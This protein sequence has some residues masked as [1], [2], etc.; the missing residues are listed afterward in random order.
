M[1]NKGIGELTAKRLLRF[2]IGI[3]LVF[4][5][6]IGRLFYIQIIDSEN[7]QAKALSQWSRE[8]TISAKRGDITDRNGTVLAQSASAA[9]IVA[10]PKDVAMKKVTDTALACEQIAGLLSDELT[11]DKDTVLGKLKDTTKSQ[12]ILARQITLE[13]ADKVRKIISDNK[14]SGIAINEDTVRAYPNGAFLTQ[15]LGFTDISG[16]GQEGLEKSLDKYLA[17]TDGRVISQVDAQNRK[18]DDGSDEYIAPKDGYSVALT[19]DYVLQSIAEKVCEEALEQNIA[20]AVRCILMNPSTGEI[21]AMV[22]KPDFD[23]NSPP[24]ND[25][26]LLSSLMRNACVT[27]AYEPGSTFKILTTS[28]A[29]NEGVVTVDST[30]T[31]RGFELVDGD[32]IKCWRS[33]NPHGQQTLVQGVCNSCNPVFINLALRLGAEKFYMGLDAFGIGKQPNIDLPGASGGQLIPIK[34]VKNVD[35]ARIGF[36]QS[37]SVSPVQL[38]TAACAAVNGGNVMKPYIVKEMIDSE[39][40]NVVTYSPEAVSQ[41]ITAETSAL[42][43]QILETAVTDGGGRNAYIPGYRVGGKTGTAQKYVNGVVSS[44]LHICSFLGFAPMDDPQL[45]ILLIVDEPGVRPDY[46]S[47]VAAPFAREILEE[48]LQYMGIEPVYEGEEEKL[49]TKEVTVPDVLGMSNEEASAALTKVGLRCMT[50]GIGSK[51]AEQLPAGG[52]SVP[53]GSLVMLYTQLSEEDEPPTNT[54]GLIEVPDVSGMS[55]IQAG[56]LLRAKGLS[57][58]LSGSGLATEQSPKAGT[59]IDPEKEDASLV[60]RVKFA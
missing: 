36:G 20:K 57:M 3:A 58:K 47:T 40:Q 44:E 54:E 49:A 12:Q 30:F 14:I 60:V 56:R 28:L 8:F 35:I 4:V 34:Y 48:S 7:L 51:I 23:L 50:D 42:M 29:L 53:E 39:G 18:M 38:L 11:L 6:L 43:R 26:D 5:L 32:K 15:V 27:D 55:M 16:Q 59:W 52:A 19:V 21:Y 24:R 31:C 41:P 46:G 45:A 1:P 22:N 33:G 17:G 10:T 13:Q 37:V 25:L 2:L 9:T